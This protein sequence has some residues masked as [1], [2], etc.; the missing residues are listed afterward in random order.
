VLTLFLLTDLNI[1]LRPTI[2]NMKP[3]TRVVSNSFGM[4]D[5]VPDQTVQLTQNCSSFCRAHLWIVPARV[6][7]VWKSA[8]G[9]LV[10]EQK[11]QKLSGRLSAGNVVAPLTDG[12]MIGDEISFTAG[13]TLYSGRVKGEEIV[14]TSRSA[15][16]SPTPWQA[17]R[18]AK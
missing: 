12:K 15:A 14:G 6:D 1:R 5:W 4:G 18:V 11:Y 8:A 16:G 2:L 7:G 17:A 13:G 9:D 10:L 3:G